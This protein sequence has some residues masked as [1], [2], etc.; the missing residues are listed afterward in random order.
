MKLYLSFLTHFSSFCV[1][2]TCSVGLFFRSAFLNIALLFPPHVVFIPFIFSSEFNFS[3]IYLVPLP[4][5]LGNANSSF[6]SLLDFFFL[7]VLWFLIYNE[8]FILFFSLGMVSGLG[9]RSAP[10]ESFWICFCAFFSP[11][12]MTACD[13]LFCT[14]LGLKVVACLGGCTLRL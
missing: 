8:V 2:W 4:Q 5:V 12:F 14:L 1:Y 6:A 7:C 11:N 10:P 13:Q 9:F 3:L